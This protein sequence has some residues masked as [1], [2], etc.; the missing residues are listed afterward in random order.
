MLRSDARF[1]PGRPP[2]TCR[3]GGDLAP[4][5]ASRGLCPAWA[6]EPDRPGL[7][8]LGLCHSDVGRCLAVG[9]AVRPPYGGLMRYD[10]D[11]NATP[12]GIAGQVMNFVRNHL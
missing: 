8:G 12:R 5:R 3:I 2:E 6:G 11:V 10:N 1:Q 7:S 4:R 9:G